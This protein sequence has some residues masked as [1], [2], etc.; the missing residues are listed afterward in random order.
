MQMRMIRNSVYDL[1]DKD[2]TQVKT[3]YGL[4]G[5]HS[6]KSQRQKKERG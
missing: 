2:M 1:L 5:K 6:Q 3:G 4:K